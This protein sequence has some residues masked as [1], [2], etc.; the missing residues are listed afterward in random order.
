MVST[1]SAHLNT[2]QSRSF[3]LAQQYPPL[4]SRTVTLGGIHLT[5][6]PHSSLGSPIR[7]GLVIEFIST[8]LKPAGDPKPTQ[9]PTGAGAIFHPRVGLGGCHGCG[10]GWVFIKHAPNTASLP[11][12]KV[13]PILKH[14]R[15]CKHCDLHP[16]CKEFFSELIAQ[17]VVTGKATKI[18]Y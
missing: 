12:L 9:N 1:Q 15:G 17:R 14:V 18:F 7:C 5:H 4:K 16:R 10:R 3:G 13:S 11:S 6:Q 8:L 2:C